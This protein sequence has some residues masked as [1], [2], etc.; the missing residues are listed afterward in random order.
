MTLGENLDNIAKAMARQRFSAGS[1][2]DAFNFEVTR[3]NHGLTFRRDKLTVTVEGFKLVDERTWSQRE[4]SAPPVIDPYRNMRRYW[5]EA[6]VSFSVG[7]VK[8][9]EHV[10]L[11]Y[12]PRIDGLLAPL[13]T[14]FERQLIADLL[15]AIEH[16]LAVAF[17]DELLDKHTYPEGG[18]CHSHAED[19]VGK[20]LKHWLGGP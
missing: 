20:R 17:N 3:R 13:G 14:R 1:N 4:P 16:Q 10:A 8:G 15:T 5:Y 19:S 12:P 11:G 9:S 2:L 18:P 7:G 6:T